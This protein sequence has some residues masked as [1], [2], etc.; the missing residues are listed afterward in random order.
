MSGALIPLPP[1]RQREIAVHEVLADLAPL[2]EQLRDALPLVNDAALRPGIDRLSDFAASA[3][4]VLDRRPDGI[5]QVL[6]DD[7]ANLLGNL[8]QLRLPARDPDMGFTL[9]LREVNGA[10]GQIAMVMMATIAAAAEMGLRPSE[11]DIARLD[12]AE[13]PKA[14]LAGQ[15]AALAARL[16]NVLA[17]LDRLQTANAPTQIGLV[18]FYLGEMRVETNLAKLSLTIGDTTIDFTSLTRAVEAMVRL[19][20][21]FLATLRGWAERVAAAIQTAGEGMLYPVWRVARGVRASVGWL[22]HKFYEARRR[23]EAEPLPDFSMH[24]VRE[25]ILAGKEIPP[26]WVPLVT[27]LDLSR[28]GLTDAT[29]LAGLTAL[30]SLD[31][32]G[33]PVS[34]ATPLA[35]LTALQRLDLSDTQVSDATPLAGL[36]ALQRLDLSG[37]PVS[38]ATPLAGLTALQYLELR[39]TPVSDATPLAGLT[40]LQS[41]YLWGTKVSDAT[42]LAGLTALQRLDLSDTQ[43]SD[44]TPLAGLTAL[45]TL[46]LEGTQVS[47]VTPLAGLTAL[48][49]LDLTRTRVTDVSPLRQ[50]DLEIRGGPGGLVRAAS[51]IRRRLFNPKP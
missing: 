48:E 10:Q 17:G 32:R 18:N 1:G 41:L 2:L 36:T 45:Q 12:A 13:V 39:G 23:S 40:A 38:D 6:I 42:P 15:V 19:T 37:T 3:T 27:E 21:D 51:A 22:A 35:G 49:E 24:A 7:I 31:L 11:P 47:D 29:P 43:V 33:T 8:R 5:D 50:L 20:G 14:L 4:L 25:L 28:S 9:G 44:A 34:D 16:D 26:V 30:R 46:D